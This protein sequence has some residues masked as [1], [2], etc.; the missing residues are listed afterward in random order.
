MSNLLTQYSALDPAPL[1]GEVVTLWH[2]L[3]EDVAGQAADIAERFDVQVRLACLCPSVAVQDFHAGTNGHAVDVSAAA[4]LD[5]QC[6]TND[7]EADHLRA[8]LLL[9][10]LLQRLGFKRTVAAFKA[11]VRWAA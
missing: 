1:P 8:D 7:P 4:D 3:G 2:D 10:E 5:G 9:C 6:H 11:V